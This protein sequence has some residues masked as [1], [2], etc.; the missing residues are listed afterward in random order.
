V[1]YFRLVLALIIMI[2]HLVYVG[3][4]WGGT[5]LVIFYAISGYGITASGIKPGF[6]Q[7]RLWRL[8]PTYAAIALI[9]TIALLMGWI[10]GRPFI[11]LPYGLGWLT[12]VLMIVPT[13]PNPALVPSAWML[14]WILLGYLAM[15]LGV[16]K[17]PERSAIWLL[18]SMSASVFY[19]ARTQSYGLWYQ[20]FLAASLATAVGACCYHMGL[21]FPRDGRWGSVA[22][23]LS[24]PV[25]LSHYGVGAAVASA[26]GWSVGWP[27]FFASLPPTLFLSWLLWRFIDVPINQYR[28]SIAIHH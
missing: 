24:Y 5:S 28:K 26:T 16:S 18:F 6:W 3:N 23:A 25:F 9:T 7:R 1:G 21:V 22:G 14:K 17:T 2:S 11:A 4:E 20:S 27:L 12:Q 13:W 8:W 19:M 15:W 10:P